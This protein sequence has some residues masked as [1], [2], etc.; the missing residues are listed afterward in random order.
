MMCKQLRYLIVLLLHLT[1]IDATTRSESLTIKALCSI[2]IPLTFLPDE[3]QCDKF[4]I[5][6]GRKDNSYQESKCGQGYHFSSQK[7]SCIKGPCATDESNA[8]SCQKAKDGTSSVRRLRND[9]TRYE[10]C[11]SDGEL[12]IV[13]CSYGHYFDAERNACLPVTITPAHQCSC[14][15]PEHTMLPNAKDCTSYYRCEEGKAVLQHCPTHNYYDAS[16]N[17]CLLDVK[18]TCRPAIPA[19]EIGE[20][21]SDCA[22]EGSRLLPHSHNCSRYLACLGSRAIELTCPYGHYFDVVSQYCAPDVAGRCHMAI[23]AIPALVSEELISEKQTEEVVSE[24]Q[25]EEAISEKQ[26]QEVIVQ[27]QAQQLL[28]NHRSPKETIHRPIIYP[29]G[30]INKLASKFLND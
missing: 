26:T 7:K 25:T 29:D 2:A 16:V 8:T 28:N 24:K 17:S 9:C 27:E 13:R 11:S 20:W 5:C 21:L 4:Y 15:L 23:T 1:I 6:T 30:I 12:A 14:I 3:R 18:G 19:P 22:G 10:R